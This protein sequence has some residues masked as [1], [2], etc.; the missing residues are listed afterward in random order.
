MRSEDILPNYC[1]INISKAKRFLSD[2]KDNFHNFFNASNCKIH[3]RYMY[4]FYEK[5]NHELKDSN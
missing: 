2:N 3:E 4:P 5:S 1:E